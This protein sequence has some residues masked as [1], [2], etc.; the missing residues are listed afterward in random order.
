MWKIFP[1]K[2][3]LG[4]GFYYTGNGVHQLIVLPEEKLVYVF[5][6]NTDGEFID[7]EDSALE[8]LFLMI[9]DAKMVI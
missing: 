7:P 4:Y 8:D 1:E 2:S 6:M 9:M 3:E 5:L